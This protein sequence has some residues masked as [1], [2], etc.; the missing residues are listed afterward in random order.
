MAKGSVKSC[1]ISTI[2]AIILLEGV[3]SL[4]NFS[5]SFDYFPTNVYIPETA[6]FGDIIWRCNATDG[7][8]SSTPAGQLRYQMNTNVFVPRWV[9]DSGYCIMYLNTKLDYE[10]QLTHTLRVV[11]RDLD[12]TAPRSTTGTMTIHV[13]DTNDNHPVCT[14][15]NRVLYVSEDTA[16]GTVIAKAV[17]SD[18]DRD[19]ST[20]GKILYKIS[21]S[22]IVEVNDRFEI[23]PDGSVNLKK[24]LDYERVKFYVLTIDVYDNGGSNSLTTSITYNIQVKDIDDNKPT[25]STNPLTVYV[26]ESAAL[27]TGVFTLTAIDADKPLTAASTIKY[28]IKTPAVPD[29]FGIDSQT[30]VVY[31][32]GILDRHI[33]PC[34]TMEVYAYSSNKSNDR[35]ELVADIRLT[36]GIT[37]S[38]QSCEVIKDVTTK[39]TVT[40]P[41]TSTY[42]SSKEPSVL[43]TV[44]EKAIVTTKPTEKLTSKPTVKTTVTAKPT[45]KTTVKT[46]VTAKPTVKTTVTEKLTVKPTEKATVTTKPTEKLTAKPTEKLTAKP[47]EKAT[48]TT[49]PTEKLTAKP[50]EKLTAKP[51]EK[52]TAKPTEKATAKPTEKATVPT[53]PT[54]KL[55]AKPTEKTTAKPTVTAKPTEKATAKAT[56]T[57]KPTEKVTV[58]AKPYVSEKPIVSK[59]LKG[60]EVDNNNEFLKGFG[61]GIGS[62][63]AFLIIII[64]VIVIIYKYR[65]M[66]IYKI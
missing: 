34:V 38:K 13:K 11:V 44:T 56:V 50:T 5:P 29:W 46:T 47:T 3:S 31:V 33:S 15:Y 41:E 55:T 45:V 24:Q 58:S 65:K 18:S 10:S 37:T 35:S 22:N 64:L 49:K 26:Q 23:L 66:R 48:V 8:D 52:A 27:G 59:K 4:N 61:T 25:W 17:C 20:H 53:K 60:D 21:D 43:T 32:K 1:V 62:T 6:T 14:E 63:L 9:L 30:G 28:G 40:D 36:D 42:T 54:E 51:T 39:S 12:P 19:K 57:A 7:D 2:I 16:V